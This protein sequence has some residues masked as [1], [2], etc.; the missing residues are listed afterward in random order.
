[1]PQTSQYTE[2]SQRRTTPLSRRRQTKTFPVKTNKK[3][4]RV[5][6]Y[7]N[8]KTNNSITKFKDRPELIRTQ[9]N[10]E[11]NN[12]RKP[13]ILIKQRRIM[14]SDNLNSVNTEINDINT[15]DVDLSD[16]EINDSV[17]IERTVQN[18]EENT[19]EV[20]KEVEKE[21]ENIDVSE[22]IA[23]H[24]LNDIPQAEDNSR[25]AEETEVEDTLEDV[26]NATENTTI[27]I[28]DINKP[29]EDQTEPT[30]KDSNEVSGEEIEKNATEPLDKVSNEIL[31]E[32]QHNHTTEALDT[33]LNEVSKN[34][35][36]PSKNSD[37]IPQDLINDVPKD[38]STD[39]FDNTMESNTK[40]QEISNLPPKDSDLPEINNSL[41]MY[42][43]QSVLS[44]SVG[45]ERDVSNVNSNSSNSKILSQTTNLETAPAPQLSEEH[46]KPLNPQYDNQ[47]KQ[48]VFTK[49]TTRNGSNNTTSDSSVSD[50]N[51][52]NKTDSLIF[53][54]SGLTL[55]NM[56]SQPS[57]KNLGHHSHTNSMQRT[58]SQQ[59]LQRQESYLSFKVPE[60]LQQKLQ[61][62]NLKN[63][64]ANQ[65]KSPVPPP[66]EVKESQNRSVNEPEPRQNHFMSQKKGSSL[67]PLS[68]PP[69]MKEASSTST[70]F[71][72]KSSIESPNKESLLSK[73]TKTQNNA[74]HEVDFSTLDLSS[75]LSTQEPELETR[76][77]Q[78]LWLQRENVATLNDSED[79]NNRNALNYIN[80]TTR[81]QYEQVSREFLNVR[82]YTNPVL[83]SLT[84]IQETK[85]LRQRV[86]IDGSSSGDHS[87]HISKSVKQQMFAQSI[88]KSLG[89]S[90]KEAETK[91]EDTFTTNIEDYNKILLDM[92]NENCIKFTDSTTSMKNQELNK[93]QQQQQQR[94]NSNSYNQ[95]QNMQ[96]IQQQQMQQQYQQNQQDNL[97]YPNQS[98]NM[99]NNNN[100]SQLA[101]TY[102]RGNR[103]LFGQQQNYNNDNRPHTSAYSS[104]VGMNSRYHPTTRAQQQQHQQQQQQQHQQHHHHQQLLQQQQQ[105]QQLNL[106]Q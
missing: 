14:S 99:N 94:Y 104:N 84:R 7:T 93:Q 49:V 54:Q 67:S 81:F 87:S 36:T 86:S 4:S 18:T 46:R 21:S 91:T 103:T 26:N 72:P 92:W 75:Y 15:A 63:S 95:Q 61:L 82:R 64:M 96:Q 51:S 101:N 10:I 25:V 89:F 69:P 12:S 2:D 53:Q 59:S 62:T 20:E 40:S 24:T 23:E 55:Y 28:N 58:V 90:L 85:N 106:Q 100:T 57:N 31:E 48:N 60:N 33:K 80:Q 1:M 39:K 45:E 74:S 37:E 38:V 11:L 73:Q 19:P 6:S 68:T 22:V 71:K 76:T 102:S 105:Q 78:K 35:P 43:M 56:N 42:R 34:D 88:S 83:E 29:A 30:V 5:S 50:T 32:L 3:P 27:E 41:T 79:G 52:V 77:Q 17:V 47:P 44:Q 13:L 8:L 98:S 97:R 65:I 16:D 9:S 66:A 70:I